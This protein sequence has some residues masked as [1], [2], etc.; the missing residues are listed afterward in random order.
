MLPSAC[1]LCAVVC[2]GTNTLRHFHSMTFNL[3]TVPK[4]RGGDHSANFGGYTVKRK[5]DIDVKQRQLR[6]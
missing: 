4:H 1:Q 5:K 6:K 2:L 3:H